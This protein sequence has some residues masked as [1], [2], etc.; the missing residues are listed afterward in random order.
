MTRK[1]VRSTGYKR[2]RLVAS[3]IVWALIVLAIIMEATS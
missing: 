1:I 3:A 2:A